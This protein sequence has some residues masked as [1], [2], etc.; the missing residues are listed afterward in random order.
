MLQIALANLLAITRT[1][2][3]GAAP[4]AALAPI[5]KALKEEFEVK[6]TQREQRMESRLKVLGEELRAEL[7]EELR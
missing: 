7:R 6:F 5:V 4:D 2:G 3:L 1:S